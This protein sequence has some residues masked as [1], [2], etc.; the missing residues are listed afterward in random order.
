MT[1]IPGFERSY[2][3]RA[4]EESKRVNRRP[5]RTS[6]KI[7]NDPMQRVIPLNSTRR[8][9]LGGHFT[10]GAILCSSLG[11]EKR[12]GGRGNQ[13]TIIIGAC[14]RRGRSC[15]QRRAPASP[16]PFTSS[17]SSKMEVPTS[18][19]PESSMIGVV[20]GTDSSKETSQVSTNCRDSRT[21]TRKARELKEY[22]RRTPSSDRDSNLSKCPP[23]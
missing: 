7:S 5:C 11:L 14:S 19:S 12:S 18:S 22:P 9:S 15:S 4:G 8:L 1:N 16:A 23:S 20:Q 21:H 17:S 6:M 3:S 2:K 13:S 10:R